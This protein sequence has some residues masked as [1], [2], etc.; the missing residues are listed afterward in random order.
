VSKEEVA[1]GRKGSGEA[2]GPTSRNAGLA[3]NGRI[4]TLAKCRSSGCGLRFGGAEN[5][6]LAIRLQ[7]FKDIFQRRPYEQFEVLSALV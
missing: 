3:Q 2:W 4:Q 1:V 6:L 5:D 7:K